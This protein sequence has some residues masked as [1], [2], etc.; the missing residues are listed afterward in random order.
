MA[1]ESNG[2]LR[3][4]WRNRIDRQQR[5]GQT[6]TQF[7]LQEGVSTPSYYKWKRKLQTEQPARRKG[8]TVRRKVKAP[9]HHKPKASAPSASPPFVQLPLPSPPSCPWIEVVLSEGT[10]VRLPQ[11]NLAAL[12]AVLGALGNNAQPS[13]MDEA[14]YA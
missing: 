9:K 3:K 8:A 14:R 11:Q 10:I 4:T 1:Q 13:L 12:K 7:C 6:V 2:Q 5:S